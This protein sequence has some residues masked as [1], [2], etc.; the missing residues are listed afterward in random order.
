[1]TVTVRIDP[2]RCRGH[3]ICA[4]LYTEGIELDEWGFGRVIEPTPEG[5]SGLR[6]ALRVVAACPNNAIVLS[7]IEGTPPQA[8]HR[9]RSVQ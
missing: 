6:R 4:L 2:I 3:A 7:G 1:M 9:P 8:R 5:R